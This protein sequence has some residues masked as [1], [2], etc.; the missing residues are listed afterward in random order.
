MALTKINKHKITSSPDR[1]GI[2]KQTTQ[3]PNTWSTWVLQITS[4]KG[5]PIMNRKLRWKRYGP[6][7]PII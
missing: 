2:H 1:C 5:V 4:S 6:K 3:F 7:I